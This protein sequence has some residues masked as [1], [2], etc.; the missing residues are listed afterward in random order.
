VPGER[1]AIR[2]LWIHVGWP[3]AVIG[4]AAVYVSLPGI[5]GDCVFLLGN[6]LPVAAIVVSLRIYRVSYK[7]PWYLAGTGV[8]LMAVPN[9]AWIIEVD[10]QG[11]QSTN[12][13]VYLALACGHLTLLSGSIAVVLRHAPTDPGGVLHAA[14][15]GLG[16]SGPTWEVL[17][18]PRLVA[19]GVPSIRQGTL[20]ITVLALMTLLGTLLRVLTT[21]VKARANIYYLLLAMAG[22]MVGVI[23]TT[24]TS[25]P[26]RTTATLLA[27]SVWFTA[28]FG[29]AAA[30]LHPSVVDLTTPEGEHP[31]DLSARRLLSTATVLSMP[32]LTAG[33]SLVVGRTPDILLLIVSMLVSIPLLLVRFWNLA[34][35]RMKAEQAL[36]HQASHDELTGLPNRRT[37]LEEVDSAVRRLRAGTLPSVAIFFCDLDGFKPINDNLGH[38]AGDEVLR[39]VARRLQGCIR[40]TDTRGTDTRGTDSR[41]TDSRAKDLVGRFGGDEFLIVCTGVSGPAIDDITERI[42]RSL[43]EPIQVQG[44]MCVVGASIGVAVATADDD[45]SGES[46]IA[47]SDQAM[48]AIKQARGGARRA[49]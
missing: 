14:L 6:L 7:V 34:L 47:R 12:P 32:A 23:L 20:L 29:C 38:Q 2:P 39:V 9:L 35:R 26:D 43:A 22:G 8:S 5:V 1:P 42:R 18:H 15:V 4:F 28:Y 44:T 25:G 36:A 10:L 49:A 30:A 31:D 21:T 16:L 41:G 11:H 40:G 3:I 27:E 48:Y 33:V 19:G 13:L 24:L 37:L 46:L 17:L 45:A